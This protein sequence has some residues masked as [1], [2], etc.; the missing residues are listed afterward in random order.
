MRADTDDLS[1]LQDDLATLA[2]RVTVA[3]LACDGLA[4]LHDQRGD[5]ARVDALQRSAERLHAAWSYLQSSAVL[6]RV[7][8]DGEDTTDTPEH[9]PMTSAACGCPTNAAGDIPCHRCGERVN[10]RCWNCGTPRGGGSCPHPVP[11][12]SESI[13]EGYGA[14]SAPADGP[15]EVP[16]ATE[17][18]ED[19][20]TWC[21]GADGACVLPDGHRGDHLT[22]SPSGVKLVVPFPAA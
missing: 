8:E 4:A 12:R 10:V 14:P 18:T 15:D 6:L 5:V 20:S 7:A 11:D 21:A 17:P 3:A 1:D 9:P 13:T 19:T 16:A 22:P 2:R